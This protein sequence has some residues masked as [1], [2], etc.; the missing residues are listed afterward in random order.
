MLR[1]KLVVQLMVL[2]G[3]HVHGTQFRFLGI[4]VQT[5]LIGK[6]ECLVFVKK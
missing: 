4:V 5:Q 3:V 6:G 1:H 2:G